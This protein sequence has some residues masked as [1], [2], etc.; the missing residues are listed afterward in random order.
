MYKILPIPVAARSKEWVFGCSLVG[1][2][3][4]NPAGA[5]L[6]L[7]SAVCCRVQVSASGCSLVQRITTECGVSVCDREAS[8]MRS[9]WSTRSCLAMGVFPMAQNFTIMMKNEKKK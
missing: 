3:G 8:I 7:V 6:S 5:W 2:A 4:S 1:I 9:H